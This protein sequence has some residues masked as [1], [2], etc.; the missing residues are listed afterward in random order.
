VHW[1]P[2]AAG[3]FALSAANTLPRPG[4]AEVGASHADIADRGRRRDGA[5]ARPAD[6]TTMTQH[7]LLRRHLEAL[8][9]EGER[10]L[11]DAL[12]AQVRVVEIAGGRTLMRQ[13]DAGDAMY[14]VVSGRL[15]AFVDA[16]GTPRHVGDATRG[17]VVGERSLY[18]GTP[19]S[20]TVVAVRDSV[21]ARLDAADFERLLPRHPA[22]SVALARH[23]FGRHPVDGAAPPPLRPATM[24]LLPIT[25]GVDALE[26]AHRLAAA[27][28]P[29]GRAAVVDAGRVDHDLGEAGVARRDA[30]DADANRRIALRLDEIEATH[31]FVLLVGDAEP[32]AWTHRCSRHA[33][34]VLLL[35]DASCEPALHPNELECLGARPAPGRATEVLVLL[36]PAGARSPRGTGAW[37]ARRPVADH[38][39]VRPD[40]ARDLARLARLQSRT[41]VGLVFAG[42]G[43]RGFAHLGVYRALRERGIEIDCVGG[44]SIGAVMATYVASDEPPDVV[45]ANARRAF[46]TNPTG[47]FDWL[48]LLALAR[49]RRLRATLRQA[50]EALVG[51]DADVEDLWK[52]HYGVATNVSQA[53]EQV[54]RRGNLVRALLA[55]IAIPGA[56]PPVACDGDLL[57]DGGTFN[58][59]P[60]DVMRAMRGVGRVIGVD[61]DR[62]ET[63]A[64]DGDELP[65]RLALLRDR[66]RPR[67]HRRLRLPW[68]PGYLRRVTTLYSTSRQREAQ[69][70]TDLCFQPP[71]ERVGLMDWHRFDRILGQGYRHACAR[72][73]AAADEWRS[74]PTA[75]MSTPGP[76]RVA[77][78]S[79]PV[80]SLSGEPAA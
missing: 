52:N 51:F 7:R 27:L 65:G 19:R 35:A 12:Q 20:A 67:R 70:M 80:L 63:V 71:L 15:R 33:D 79:M 45:E 61:L 36:H 57:C 5:A 18:T 41:A 13:G 39:H 2:N 50:I 56:L 55:T 69:T 62:P 21:L 42:G 25:A 78:D 30:G 49:G 60:V 73:D 37:L 76:H 64:V 58:N 32:T 34:E 40:V 59:F 47:D 54:L 43:A 66:L 3:I 53:R 6:P 9:G 10:A 68:L 11:V 17:Q 16:D 28:A 31:D 22:L 1:L 23:V 48:P 38:V 26:F 4:R 24:A 44:T 14:L 77:A 72:L 29:I 74:W 75:R 8:L 46:A